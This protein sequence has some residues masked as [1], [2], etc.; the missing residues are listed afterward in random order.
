MFIGD[1]LIKVDITILLRCQISTHILEKIRF[2]VP[3]LGVAHVQVA[4]GSLF[5][6]LEMVIL[7]TFAKNC[8]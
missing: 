6:K 3:Y 1:E 8:L 7:R 4:A 5:W 2:V